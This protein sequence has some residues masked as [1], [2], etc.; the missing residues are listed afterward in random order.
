MAPTR[1]VEEP[2]KGKDD[3]GGAITGRLAV[4]HQAQRDA[5]ADAR[6]NDEV[7]EV[8]MS[9]C[10]WL[11]VCERMNRRSPITTAAIATAET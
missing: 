6:G 9:I 7:G 11:S 3:P 10:P 2:S 1:E 8:H 5:P 4:E